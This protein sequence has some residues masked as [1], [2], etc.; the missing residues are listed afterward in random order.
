MP[1]FPIKR[2]IARENGGFNVP[3]IIIVNVNKEKLSRRMMRISLNCN[4]A[5]RMF[6][7][8][9]KPAEGKPIELSLFLFYH[10]CRP[11]SQKHNK[12]LSFI[13]KVNYFYSSTLASFSCHLNFQRFIKTLDKHVQ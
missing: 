12:A 5:A 9:R 2:L 6:C 7:V 11:Y 4:S 13:D 1:N 10:H 3:L 8:V